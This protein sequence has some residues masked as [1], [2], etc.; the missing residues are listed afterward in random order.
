MPPSE[1]ISTTNQIVICSKLVLS[2][3]GALQRMGYVVSEAQILVNVLMVLRVQTH[4]CKDN[5]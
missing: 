1:V 4:L 5:F 3:K 2:E